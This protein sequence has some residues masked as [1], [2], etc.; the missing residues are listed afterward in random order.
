MFSKVIVKSSKLSLQKQTSREW[1]GIFFF[2][3]TDEKGGSWRKVVLNISIR[4][5]ENDCLRSPMKKNIVTSTLA[6]IQR[7]RKN[8]CDSAQFW[9]IK[10]TH[11]LFHTPYRLASA[12]FYNSCWKK[13]IKWK[14]FTLY[15]KETAKNTHTVHKSF[16]QQLLMWETGILGKD[17]FSELPGKMKNLA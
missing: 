2:P 6:G 3:S 13:W 14:I 16:L 1:C 17:K 7:T 9:S 11:S 5:V 10:R 12:C 4:F 15:S 8:L